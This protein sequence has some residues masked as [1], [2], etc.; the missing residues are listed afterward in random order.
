MEQNVIGQRLKLLRKKG[1][2]HKKNLRRNWL[3]S[4]NLSLPDMSLGQSCRPIPFLLN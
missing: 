1:N 4:N 3:M 2:F